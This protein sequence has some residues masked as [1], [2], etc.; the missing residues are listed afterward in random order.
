MEVLYFVLNLAA[1]YYFSWAA[2]VQGSIIAAFLQV[3]LSH[4]CDMCPSVGKKVI[5]L[6]ELSSAE[7][8]L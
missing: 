2:F 7:H 8:L 4:E 5:G 3:S 1:L 6:K